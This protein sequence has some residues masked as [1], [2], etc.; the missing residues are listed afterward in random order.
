MVETPQ[1]AARQEMDTTI[2][3]A[4]AREVLCPLRQYKESLH[5]G[6]TPRIPTPVHSQ[7][8]PDCKWSY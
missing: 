3:D 6:D 7:G 2:H 8:D 5:R 1:E 4:R